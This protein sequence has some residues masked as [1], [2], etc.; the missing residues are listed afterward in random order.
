M[1]EEKVNG[2]RDV[3]GERVKEKKTHEHIKNRLKRKTTYR[4]KE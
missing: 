2:K 1:M 3:E 4:E